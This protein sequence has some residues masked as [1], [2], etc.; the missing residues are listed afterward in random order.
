MENC[1]CIEQRS[2]IKEPLITISEA[3][4]NRPWQKVGM[5]LFKLDVWYLIIVDY[6]SRYFEI[7]RLKTLTECEVINKCKEA[8]ARYGVPEIVRSDCGTQF[9][10]QFRNFATDYDFQHVTSS[11]IPIFAKQW[12]R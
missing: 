9:A 5:D 3:F 4:P 8:F 7:F 2:N 6:Y 12:C 10:S 1:R 11:P